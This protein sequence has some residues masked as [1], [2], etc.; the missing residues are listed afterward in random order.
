MMSQQDVQELNRILFSALETSLI[1][2]SGS[3]LI[4]RLYRGTLINLITCSECHNVSERQ[5][6]VCV[7][8]SPQTF[9]PLV[10]KSVLGSIT[11]VEF[12][13]D[14]QLDFLTDDGA[15]QPYQV[16]VYVCVCACG[17]YF[18]AVFKKLTREPW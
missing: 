12:F 10:G 3:S 6:C 1:G 7:V 13:S 14:R 18:S 2:T 15:C 11:A 16:S 9:K 4:Q 17:L 8:L 5:V